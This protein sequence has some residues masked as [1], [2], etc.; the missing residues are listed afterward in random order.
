MNVKI[1]SAYVVNFISR[2]IKGIL[3][4]AARAYAAAR[5]VVLSEKTA[6]ADGGGSFLN[7]IVFI[8]KNYLLMQRCG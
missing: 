3:H 5:F 7:R 8:L 6:P 4:H 1:T 2:N